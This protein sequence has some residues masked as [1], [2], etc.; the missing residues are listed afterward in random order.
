MD[1]LKTDGRETVGGRKLLQTLPPL[2]IQ[3]QQPP[4]TSIRRL[5]AQ[6][7]GVTRSSIQRILKKDLGMQGYRASLVQELKEDDP[8]LRIQWAELWLEKVRQNPSFPDQQDGAPAHYLRGVRDWLNETFGTKWIGRGGPLESPA[9]SPELTPMDFWLWGYLKENVYAHN[10]KTV[11]QLQVVIAQEMSAL[12]PAMI[13][14]ATSSVTTRYQ[15]LIDNYGLQ[16]N[17]G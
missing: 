6:N 5:Q 16:L 4:T 9:R 13:Q 1:L 8:A 7:P 3:W 2:E 17:I 12:D 10:P 11:D 15:R 14:R